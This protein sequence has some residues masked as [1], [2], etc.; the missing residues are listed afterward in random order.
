MGS[1]FNI[2][3]FKYTGIE[4]IAKRTRHLLNIETLNN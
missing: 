2:L 3:S 4:I 1:H